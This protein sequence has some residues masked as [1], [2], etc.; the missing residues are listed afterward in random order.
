M[1]QVHTTQIRLWRVLGSRQQHTQLILRCA[2]YKGQ[3]SCLLTLAYGGLPPMVRPVRPPTTAR[4]PLGNVPPHCTVSTALPGLGRGASC[5]LDVDSCPA[6]KSSAIWRY[7]LQMR[8]LWHA[9][10]M[11]SCTLGRL[12]TCTGWRARLC[13]CVSRSLQLQTSCVAWQC[14][15]SVCAYDGARM[16]FACGVNMVVQQGRPAC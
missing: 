11:R 6:V 14:A 12:W 5:V 13:Y 8:M 2:G 15:L 10:T 1:L 7:E 16:G 4:R 9:Y 3:V